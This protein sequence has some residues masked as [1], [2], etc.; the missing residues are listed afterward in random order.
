L[1]APNGA[2][3]LGNNVFEKKDMYSMLRTTANVEAAMTGMTMA[4]VVRL[5]RSSLML[6]K[7]CNEAVVRITLYWR[8]FEIR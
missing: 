7:D 5:K 1:R 3:T 2:K 4:K 8:F 6:Q